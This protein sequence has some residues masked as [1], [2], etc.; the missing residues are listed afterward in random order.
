MRVRPLPSCP[1]RNLA[2]LTS[3]RPRTHTKPVPKWDRSQPM[4]RSDTD[5]EAGS[6][7]L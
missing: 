3:D 1:L 7:G 4:H 2:E 5:P 6:C